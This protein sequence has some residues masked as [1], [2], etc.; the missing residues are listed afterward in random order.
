MVVSALFRQNMAQPEQT[1][2]MLNE[3]E[4]LN[5]IERIPAAPD[6]IAEVQDFSVQPDNADKFESLWHEIASQQ[7]L[8][9]GCL[10]LRLHRDTEKP[11][12]YVGYNLWDSRRV[13]VNAIRAMPDEPAYPVSGEAHLTYVRT[14]I[15]VRGSQANPNDAKPG[16]IASLRGFY[17]KVRSEPRFERLWATSARAESHQ[18]G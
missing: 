9:P 1:S 4:L 12:H 14:A 5:R 10:F 11:S 17:L 13:L 16:Q 7:V 6:R 8:Q 2:L 15:H 3:H 18:P